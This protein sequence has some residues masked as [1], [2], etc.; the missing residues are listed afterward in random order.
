MM[1]Q[2]WPI[3]TDTSIEILEGTRHN[4]LVFVAN[5]ILFRYSATKN[6][7]TLKQ[8]FMDISYNLCKPYPSPPQEIEGIW[9]DALEYTQTNIRKRKYYSLRILG[10]D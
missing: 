6:H 8:K 1:L 5:P 10:E 9:K 3:Q 7:D 2:S 4:I